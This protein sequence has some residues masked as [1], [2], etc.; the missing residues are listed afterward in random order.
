MAKHYVGNIGTEIIVNCGTDISGATAQ[1]L[2]V[3]K[4][5]GAIVNWLATIYNTN[6]L[7]YSVASR[8]FD[9]AGVYELQAY[10]VMPS[11]IG[12]GETT[13]FTIYKSFA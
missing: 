5:S 8:D 4:P 9:E 3:K 10:I 11:W 13:T 7:K 1:S 6:F 12:R 2:K